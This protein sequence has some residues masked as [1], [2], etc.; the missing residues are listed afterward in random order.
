MKGLLKDV[1]FGGG[2]SKPSPYPSSAKWEGK[3]FHPSLK[4]IVHLH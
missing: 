1:N 4:N 2:E 3:A